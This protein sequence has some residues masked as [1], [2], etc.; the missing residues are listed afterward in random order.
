M[1]EP[2]GQYPPLTEKLV[3]RLWEEQ[4][5]FRRPLL[6]D[7]GSEVQVVYRG[8]RRW[9]RGPDFP[10][11]LIATGEAGLRHGDVEIHVR[12]GDWRLHGHHRDPYYNRVVLHVVMWD[13]APGQTVR[14]DGARVPVVALFPRLTEPLEALLTSIAQ[15][16]PRPSPCWPG[17]AEFDG[18]L[19][20][21]LD[22]CGMDRFAGKVA[23]FESGL[24]F[25]SHEQLLYH[26]IADAL[27]YTRNREPF[28][29]LAD[30]LPLETLLAYRRHSRRGDEEGGRGGEGETEAVTLSGAKGLSAGGLAPDQSPTGEMLRSAQHDSSVRPKSPVPGPQSLTPALEALL[31]GAA[32]LLPPQPQLPAF[33]TDSYVRLLRERWAA[34]GPVWAGGSMSASDWQLFRVRPANFPTRRIGALAAIVERWPEEGL[35]TWLERAARSSEPDRLPR[36]LE[37]FLLRLAPGGYWA[38][39]SD[40]GLPLP[41][42]LAL[43]GRQ[44]AAEVAVNVFLPFLGALAASQGDAGGLAARVQEAYRLYPK[45]GDNEVSRYMALQITARPRPPVARSACRQQGLLQLYRIHCERKRCWECPVQSPPTVDTYG[46]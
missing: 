33:E 35:A 43:V 44:R 14:E 9:D 22:R 45:R 17:S 29:K 5:P 31:L 25:S 7:D 8:R 34:D 12:S 36:K 28:R 39:H 21:L 13:D 6:S 42:P 18:S 27:G 41:R 24:A 40:F 23:G 11:A 38:Y 15:D 16:S 19:G 26:G 4:G 10:D 30:L 1:R 46:N 20:R 37:S 32:G 3:A 2:S